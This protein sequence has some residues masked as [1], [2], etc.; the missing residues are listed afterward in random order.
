M[1]LSTAPLLNDALIVALHVLLINSI[2]YF[3]LF[4]GNGNRNNGNNNG[5]GNGTNNV[6]N[7]NGSGNG[8]NNKGNN[9][10]TG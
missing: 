1:V 8:N 7:N 5:T 2:I 6:G 10:R 4:V 3:H 9:N